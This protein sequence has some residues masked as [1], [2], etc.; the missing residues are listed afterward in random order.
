VTRVPV[1]LIDCDWLSCPGVVVNAA[2]VSGK[3][4]KPATHIGDGGGKIPTYLGSVSV[5]RGRCIV[6]VSPTSITVDQR[7]LP[8]SINA[9]VSC[10]GRGHFTVDIHANKQVFSRVFILM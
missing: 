5:Q 4:A 3:A 9:S 7:S 6:T 1:Q 8:W 2:I 10:G